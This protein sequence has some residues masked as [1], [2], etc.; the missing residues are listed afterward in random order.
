MENK[1]ILYSFAFSVLFSAA[2]SQAHAATEIQTGTQTQTQNPDTVVNTTGNNMT[3]TTATNTTA[4]GGNQAEQN[5]K[6]GE[7]FMEENKTKADVV[8]LPSGLQYKILEK[9]TGKQPKKSDSVTV[10]YEGTLLNGQVFD[11]SYK[12]GQPATFPVSGVISGWTEALQLMH[13]GDT[14]MLYIPPHL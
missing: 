10:D 7:K 4:Q 5:L 12:R 8:T 1:L 3:D 11:S 9:G 14:W 6:N 2:I 13:E